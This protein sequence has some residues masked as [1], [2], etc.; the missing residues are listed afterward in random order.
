MKELKPEE[1]IIEAALEVVKENTI[2]GTRMHLIAERAEMVQSNLHYYY[3]TKN[4][5]M[6]ALQKKVLNR[7][8]ELR[9]RYR[10]QAKDTLEDQIEVF[11]KQKLEFVLKEQ[12]YDYAE[13]D[14]W[15][16][17][18]INE[19]MQKAFAS[20]FFGWREGIADILEKY[21]PDM[22][23][24]KKK[25][26]PYVMVSM[27]EGASIQYLID[28]GSFDVEEYFKFCKEIILKVIRD[29]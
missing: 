7:C 10:N 20:S 24:Q 23:E 13:I 14:F 12:N 22:S 21:A 17:G 6:T 19:E 16:Q 25:Y 18:R 4:D 26:L 27:L 29:F 8:L 9:D 2:S 3:K 1:K 15:V 28:V 5:L 11:I